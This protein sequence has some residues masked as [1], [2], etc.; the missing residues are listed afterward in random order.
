M[1]QGRVKPLVVAPSIVS[2]DLGPLADGGRAVDVAGARVR[3]RWPE[4]VGRSR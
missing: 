4:A 3:P 1:L 2:A